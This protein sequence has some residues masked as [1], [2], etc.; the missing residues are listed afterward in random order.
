VGRGNGTFSRR[1]ARL[2]S[3][4]LLVLDD[5]GLRPLSGQ[6]V[7]D[8]YDIIRERYE[9]KSLIITSNRA[10]EE[11]SDAFGDGLLS[12]AALDRLTHHCHTLVIRGGSYRQRGRRKEDDEPGHEIDNLVSE[13]PAPQS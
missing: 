6:G 2:I 10:F 13:G 9:R 7:E 12:S 3:L 1:F 11:W 5:F 8:L 4:D